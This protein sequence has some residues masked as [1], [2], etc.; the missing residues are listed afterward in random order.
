M[1][2]KIFQLL[3]SYVN[4]CYRHL[5]L[6]LPFLLLLLWLFLL[7]SLLLLLLALL[8]LLLLL[9]LLISFIHFTHLVARRQT[10]TWLLQTLRSFNKQDISLTL[11]VPVSLFSVAVQSCVGLA[12]PQRP[13]VGSYNTKRR[14]L[15]S[16]C[17]YQY[18]NCC[19]DFLYCCYYYHS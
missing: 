13:C 15:I 6:I 17:L 5:Q 7:F 12:L 10:T 1:V 16:E 3:S 4:Y 11:D 18:Y 8:L 9:A 2:F 19:Y 14:M